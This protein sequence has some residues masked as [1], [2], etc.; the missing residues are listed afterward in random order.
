[1]MKLFPTL[2]KELSPHSPQSLFSAAQ[3]RLPE[4]FLENHA[5]TSIHSSLCWKQRTGTQVQ[6]AAPSGSS[7]TPQKQRWR[8][9][10]WA[11]HEVLS[12][13]LHH[14][15]LT[16]SLLLICCSSFP[17]GYLPSKH[18]SS[19]SLLLQLPAL[20]HFCQSDDKSSN[21]SVTSAAAKKLLDRKN[22][23]SCPPAIAHY[24][25]GL[26]S[27]KSHCTARDKENSLCDPPSN[28]FKKTPA[29]PWTSSP[30]E[31]RAAHGLLHVPTST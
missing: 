29:W 21:S 23:I 31:K 16:S 14:A 3:K 7:P 30:V 28:T 20:A 22:L 27:Y 10:G 8:R 4:P 13:L 19:V 2:S 1:M 5:E 26:H 6:C 11:A 12:F 18:F 25:F 24:M 9:E 17:K 15:S